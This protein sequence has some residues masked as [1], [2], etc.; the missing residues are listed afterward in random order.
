MP[1]TT[2][3]SDC[4][5]THCTYSSSAIINALETDYHKRIKVIWKSIVPIKY[6]IRKEYTAISTD[7]FQNNWEFG[8][9]MWLLITLILIYNYFKA[10]VIL[11]SEIFTNN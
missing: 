3:T 8:I 7:P 6:Y 5:A 4:L 9:E 11:A 2:E 1:G 10:T